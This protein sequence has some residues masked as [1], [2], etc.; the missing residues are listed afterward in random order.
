MKKKFLVL[1]IL[2][3]VLAT[4]FIP[5]AYA[6][7]SLAPRFSLINPKDYI[8]FSPQKI[9]VNDSYVAYTEATAL[10]VL[11]RA[12]NSIGSLNIGDYTDIESMAIRDSLLFCIL[13]DDDNAL[14]RVYDLSDGTYADSTIVGLSL[15][16]YGDFMYVYYGTGYYIYDLSAVDSI[17]DA[18]TL[19]QNLSKPFDSSALFAANSQSVFAVKNGYSVSVIGLNGEK[20]SFILPFFPSALS[21]DDNYIYFLTATEL[22]VYSVADCNEVYSISSNE[23]LQTTSLFISPSVYNAKLYV[24]FSSLAGG[25]SVYDVQTNGTLLREKLLTTIGATLERLYNPLSVSSDGETVAVADAGNNRIL[26]PNAYSIRSVGAYKVAVNSTNVYFADSEGLKLYTLPNGPSTTLVA[27]II[28]KSL[29]TYGNSVFYIDDNGVF[30]YN[31]STPTLV[32]EGN[33]NDVCASFNGKI[34]YVINNENITAL[35]T[36]SNSTLF[37]VSLSAVNVSG[38]VMRFECDAY[39][40]LI[41]LSENGGVYKLTYLERKLAGYSYVDDVTLNG[42]IPTD[43]ALADDGIYFTSNEPHALTYLS[44]DE[45]R[46]CGIEYKATFTSAY[47]APDYKNATPLSQEAKIYKIENGDFN[48]FE[49]PD[50]YES[51][52]KTDENTLVYS[53]DNQDYVND[54]NAFCFVIRNG[55][56]EFIL[57]SAL[58]ELSSG[59]PSLKYGAALFSNTVVYKYPDVNSVK[60]TTLNKG[61]HIE[62]IS[63]VCGYD[64]SAWYSISVNGYVGY[65]KRADVTISKSGNEPAQDDVAKPEKY[66]AEVCSNNTMIYALADESSSIIGILKAGD[67]VELSAPYNKDDLFTFVTFGE[68]SGYVLTTSLRVPGLS[69]AQIVALVI[70][71]SAALIII[72]LRILSRKAARKKN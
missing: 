51:V 55:V 27:G 44:F 3:A 48:S 10:K 41:I 30:V 69:A 14:L 66:Y 25:I 47:T 53:V 32:A 54:G 28:V 58:T 29:K 13:R 59:V 36:E 6:D 57:K 63:D 24:S 17:D 1:L 45:L 22:H 5:V 11:S 61:A 34:A 19:S 37:T 43:F 70:I 26:I 62:T 50:G 40:N 23:S 49:S 4:S 7:G 18:L 8:D 15:Y 39:G 65:V 64:N 16:I 20:S 9:S 21:A 71:F 12:D 31:N 56:G 72:L 52:V 35:Y 68:T 60:L 33:F 67:T 46:T 2:I 38:R 42:I